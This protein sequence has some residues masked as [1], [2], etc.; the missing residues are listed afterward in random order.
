LFLLPWL[1]RNPIKSWRYRNTAHML[2]LAIFAGVFIILGYLGVKAVTPEYKEMGI[3]MTEIYFLFFGVIWI[4]SKTNLSRYVIG[5][6]VLAGAVVAID[7]WRFNPDDAV[8]AGQIMWQW[9]W[10]IGYLA[11][12]LLL[13]LLVKG[14][15]AEKT[16]PE[17]VTS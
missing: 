3:R 12:T 10:P 13:P 7:F 16:V 6:I 15:N 17:R 14:C 9:V 8:S 11:L 1:D 4:H 5:F 2:D